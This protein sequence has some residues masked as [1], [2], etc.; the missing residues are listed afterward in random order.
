MPGTMQMQADVVNH[1]KEQG[2]KTLDYII[3]T[4]PH[5]HHIGGMDVVVNSFD[6]GK[7]I[8]PKV[9]SNTKTFEDLLN[10]ISNK[11]LKITSP[12]PGTKYSLGEAE[13]IILAPNGSDYEDI[14]N[15]SVVVK[16]QFGNTSFC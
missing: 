11:G 10:A 9:Q 15:Y 12:V 14:N 2:I 16:L 7:V 1:I 5:E 6:I 3:G 8:L 13:F 4:H